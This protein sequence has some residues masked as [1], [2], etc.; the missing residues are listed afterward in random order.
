MSN[1]RPPRR[2]GATLQLTVFRKDPP[3]QRHQ[4][5]SLAL[6]EPVRQALLVPRHPLLQP[7][8]QGRSRRGEAQRVGPAVV[9]CRVAGHEAAALEIVEDGH[10]GRPVEMDGPRKIALFH[11]RIGFDQYEHGEELYCICQRPYDQRRS[12]LGCV[13]FKKLLCCS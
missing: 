9:G 2:C 8:Q 3:Q 5:G 11:P 13:L 4:R 1:N 12:M 6:V 7:A 10:D